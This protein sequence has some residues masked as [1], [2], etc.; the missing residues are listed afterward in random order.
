MIYDKLELFSR[1]TGLSKNL[2]TALSYL[3]AQ[4]FSTTHPGRVDLQGDEL[5]ALVQEY[6]TR[7][8]EQ[9]I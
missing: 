1:T 8:F 2:V 9:G 6:T 7:L 3:V 4:D 5:F